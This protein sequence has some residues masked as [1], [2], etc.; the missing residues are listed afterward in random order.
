MND[1]GIRLI[2]LLVSVLFAALLPVAVGAQSDSTLPIAPPGLHKGQPRHVKVIGPTTGVSDVQLDEPD[3]VGGEIA[4]EGAW[5]WQAAL[6]RPSSENAYRGHYCGGT[7]IAPD[8]VLTAAHCVVGLPS[9]EGVVDVVLGRNVLSAGGGERIAVDIVI[10]HPEYD[11]L[12][13]DADVALLHLSQPSVQ[14]SISFDAPDDEELE[15]TDTVATVTGWGRF[16]TGAFVGSD[17]L[18]QVELPI[19]DRARCSSEEAWGDMITENMICAGYATGDRS[20]CHG[21]SGGPLVVPIDDEPGWA[22]VGIVSWGSSTCFGRD[23]YNVYTRLSQFE[24]WVA[25]CQEN[26]AGRACRGIG[27]TGDDYE[28]DGDVELSRLIEVNGEGELHNTH[29]PQDND[30]FRFTAKAGR[31]YVLQTAQLGRR[32]DTV[33]WLYDQDRLTI[34]G[35]NDDRPSMLG[36]DDEYPYDGRGSAL[37]W[38]A[39]ESG[40]YYVLVH[41]LYSFTYGNHTDYRFRIV[42]ISPRTYLP[43]VPSLP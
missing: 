29:R 31:S 9:V 1:W 42:E 3:I 15:A 33:L 16:S 28:P 17:E 37:L 41:S 36:I 21:D 43:L 2:G 12:R 11:S 39:P 25:A 4:A 30:W 19:V 26:P 32:S 14:Q 23:R 13:L 5:P 34:L 38:Q 27:F 18:R 24:A 7:L 40:D 8:W 22:Q 6:V 20:A 10:V 35:Y